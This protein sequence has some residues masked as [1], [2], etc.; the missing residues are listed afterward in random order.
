MQTQIRETLPESETPASGIRED[1]HSRLPLILTVAALVLFMLICNLLTPMLVDDFTYSFSF[2]DG[3]PIESAADIFPSIAAHAEKMNGRHTAHFFAQL[4]LLLPDFLFEI[5]NAAIFT[6]GLCLMARIC[7]RK[8]RLWMILLLFGFHWL[9]EPAFGEVNLWLDGACNYLWGY[10]IC[11]LWLSPYFAAIDRLRPAPIGLRIA[12]IP[13]GFVAGGWNENASAASIFMAAL[14]ICAVLY[15]H[16]RVGFELILALVGA[17]GG[18][19]TMAL[20]PAESK[21]KIVELTFDL[22]RDNFVIA[23]KMLAQMAP[24][25][26]LYAVLITLAVML[27]ADGAAICKSVVL[28]LGALAS[29]YIM[30]FASYYHSRSAAFTAVLLSIACTMLLGA[31]SEKGGRRLA[32][33]TLSVTMLLTAYFV[34]IGMDDMARSHDAVMADAEYLAECR[35]TGVREATLTVITAETKYSAVKELKYIDI[36]DPDTWPNRNMAR[37][38]GL[39]AIYGE[40]DE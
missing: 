20:A 35:D 13:L 15:V 23:T 16:R 21:N 17:I 39:D 25:F 9:F 33:C 34:I 32:A 14:L 29:N 2:V 4:F 7:D 19:L 10:V 18:F 3:S 31:L 30:I 28:T 36:Y 22:L 1:R 11:L 38:Y 5:V 12:L 37:Y 24:L 26:I 40:A 8:L 6:A 27:D